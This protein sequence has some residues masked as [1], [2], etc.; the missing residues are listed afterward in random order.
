MNP[1][2]E[3]RIEKLTLNIGAGKDPAKLDKGMTLIKTITGIEPVKTITKKRIAEWGLRPG[4]P[5][6][7]KITLRKQAAHTL[8][9]RLL[10]AKDNKLT[11]KNFDEHGM[12]S[13]GIPEY[14]DIPGVPYNPSIGVIGLQVCITL[15]KK[16]YRIKRR[17]IRRQIARIQRFSG[18]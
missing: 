4:L 9:P 8:I 6:G 11:T 18:T 1:M 5:I 2:Q 10:T 17:K 15:E 12:I 7:C 16:G 3:I 13:F 14:I